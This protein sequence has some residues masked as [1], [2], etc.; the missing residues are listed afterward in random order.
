MEAKNLITE[1]NLDK[2]R[3]VRNQKGWVRN[4]GPKVQIDNLFVRDLENFQDGQPIW[5]PCVKGRDSVRVF[6]TDNY[7]NV[8]FIDLW[9][10]ALEA[11]GFSIEAGKSYTIYSFYNADKNN[12]PY[13]GTIFGHDTSRELRRIGAIACEGKLM[14]FSGLQSIPKYMIDFMTLGLNV[15]FQ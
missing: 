13:E 11:N 1:K 3:E 6:A 4:I 2:L 5:T 10:D 7:Q 12:S 8:Y 15:I 14:V 9:K